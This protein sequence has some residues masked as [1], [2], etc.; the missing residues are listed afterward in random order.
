M[1]TILARQSTP[2]P[3]YTPHLQDVEFSRLD[4]AAPSIIS[5]PP[6]YDEAAGAPSFHPTAHLQIET[7][8]KPWLSLP[9][10]LRPNPIP[11]FTLHPDESSASA[12]SHNPKFLSL[13]PERGSG[14]C[15]LVSSSDSVP[16]STTTYRFGPNRP[17]QVRLFHP[18]NPPLSPSTVRTLL[19][20]P[21]DRENPEAAGAGLGPEPWDEFTVCSLGLLTR[22]VTF[23]TRL[24]T[25]QWRYASRKERHARARAHAH[26]SSAA[27]SDRP[28]GAGGEIS[29][30]LVLERVVRIAVARNQNH[31]GSP[32]SSSR[33][34][35]GGNDE[36]VRTVVAEFMRG[37]DYRTAGSSGS[38]AGN[39]GRLVVDIGL[40]GGDGDEG[41]GKGDREMAL[42][43]VV[44]TCLLM[45][46]REVD[47]RRAQQIAI[48]TGVASGST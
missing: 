23:R 17:P 43:M 9:L 29:S 28:A 11:I 33:D 31:P 20:P 44:T 14:S 21:K 41:E 39:G 4:S 45:L 32:S 24:G 13:R 30:L 36:Q 40:I 42:V 6:P 48:M 35:A 38:S 18:A 37:P 22:A 26:T 7:T 16:L 10:P 46:K 34:G 2:S 25:F 1:T 27:A 47:R 15:Y 12:G 3:R 8:G 5:E 19:F